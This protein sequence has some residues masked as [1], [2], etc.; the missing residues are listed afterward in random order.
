MG[1]LLLAASSALGSQAQSQL[2]RCRVELRGPFDGLELSASSHG[3]L[4]VL[5]RLRAG[6]RRELNLPLARRPS[7]LEG[8]PFAGREQVRFLG[9]PEESE[10]QRWEGLPFAL[11]ARTRPVLEAARVRPN[12]AAW[13][14]LAAAAPIL[15]ALRRRP[16]RLWIV[17]PL[18]AGALVLAQVEGR[19]D[20]RQQ[21]RALEALAQPGPALLVEA[22][23]ERLRLP[24]SDP[25]LR[26][27]CLPASRSVSWTVEL[28]AGG[29][30]S[31]LATARGAQLT[32][33]SLLRAGRP[34]LVSER[35]DF[36]ALAEIW[37]RTPQGEWSARGPWPA[38]RP[39]P[40]AALEAESASARGR[41]TPPGWLLGSLPQGVGVLI[42]RV[43]S[44]RWSGAHWGD[45][46]GGR[47]PTW[48]RVS[49]FEAGP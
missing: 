10:E 26:L 49:G 48:L 29:A 45:P 33:F 18:L 22:A 30:A 43:D 13:C 7:E 36:G 25:G 44:E 31:W 40:G 39:L 1:A 15:L 20:E 12:V 11:R 5:G 24:E 4:R 21:L 32:R 28:E 34:Q 9:W 14:L 17:S 27:E 16:A 38:G 23:M 8:A 47:V 2:H 6:E 3:E 35:N 19:G 37:V 41:A 42:A 46:A